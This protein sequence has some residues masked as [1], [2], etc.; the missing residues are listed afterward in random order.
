MGIYSDVSELIGNTP[1]VKINSLSKR[2]GNNIFS[3][4]EYF[5]PVGS[6]KDRVALSI[7]DDAISSGKLKEGGTVVEATSGNTG[8]A[9]SM[10]ASL[11]G[12]KTII[13]MPETMSR[14][15]QL[16]I[17]SLGA[18]LILTDG[19]LG[20]KGSIDKAREIVNSL[21]NSILA[22]QFDNPANPN[23]HKITA[24][25]ILKDFGENLDYL[26]VGVGTGGTISGVGSELKKYMP[27]LKVVA[28][29]PSTSAVLSGEASG[30]HKIQGIGAGFVPEICDES[31]I[32]EVIKIS[33]EEAG[34]FARDIAKNEGILCGISSGANL[35]GVF[36]LAS[37]KEVVNKNILTFACDTGERYLSTWLF[38]NL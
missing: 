26:V 2:C 23:A 17:K 34:K 1:I 31:V 25:E 12:L 15:R 11:K 24:K 10:L 3:K 22:N 9:L 21:D 6:I 14:E 8:I 36:K 32:D 18:E 16:I 38:D 28:V 30:P 4:L 19:S 5:N 35:A 7:L 29:E 37:R 13:V 33:D 27:N 20:M